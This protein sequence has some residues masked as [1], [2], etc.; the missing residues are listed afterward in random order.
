MLPRYTWPCCWRTGLARSA[1]LRCWRSLRKR[2]THWL[3]SLLGTLSWRL[4]V[5]DGGRKPLSTLGRSLLLCL[6][7]P[8]LLELRWHE[9]PRTP[10]RRALWNFQQKQLEEVVRYLLG[11]TYSAKNQKLSVIG[12]RMPGVCRVE[13]VSSVYQTSFAFPLL[14]GDAG[15]QSSA[16]S[17]RILNMSSSQGSSSQALCVHMPSLS[18]T[19]LPSNSKIFYLS[20]RYYFILKIND[21]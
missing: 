9:K 17:L 15:F 10:R 18:L 16:F 6:P 14:E 8:G 2:T 5:Q 3:N 7:Q 19:F 20:I 13:V 12:W 1:G 4:C 21:W 11:L